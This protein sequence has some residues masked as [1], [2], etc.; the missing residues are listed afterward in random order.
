MLHRAM[1]VAPPVA[2]IALGSERF[3]SAHDRTRNSSP[4]KWKKGDI[5]QVCAGDGNN[6]SCHNGAGRFG[7]VG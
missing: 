1:L 7:R 5:S 4:P 3:P 2:L 6:K